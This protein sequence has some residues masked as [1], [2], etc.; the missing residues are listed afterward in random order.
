[1]CCFSLM[2]TKKAIN[3]IA[4]IEGIGDVLLGFASNLI[5]RSPAPLTRWD[6]ASLGLLL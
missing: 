4:L 1:M 2:V 3:I 5:F 6:V